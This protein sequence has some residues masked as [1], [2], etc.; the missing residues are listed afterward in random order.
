M[1]QKRDYFVFFLFDSV[2]WGCF[3]LFQRCLLLDFI[4]RFLA[5]A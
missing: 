1:Y 5:M 3:A 2:D 4:L